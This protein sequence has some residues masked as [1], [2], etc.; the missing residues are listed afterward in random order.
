MGTYLSHRNIIDAWPRLGDFADDLGISYGNAKAMRRRDRIGLEYV[1]KVVA[2]AEARG[3]DGVTAALIA[4]LA[5]DK[6]AAAK[7]AD[8]RSQQ[9]SDQQVAS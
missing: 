6:A 4:R 3:I 2:A 8:D 7:L 5:S 1:T 9:T